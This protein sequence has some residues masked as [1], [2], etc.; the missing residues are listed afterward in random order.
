[1]AKLHEYLLSEV[2]PIGRTNALF[3]KNLGYDNTNA[4]TLERDLLNLARAGDLTDSVPSDYG[5]KYVITG[6]L[7]APN[8]ENAV[9]KT[10]WII[11]R[12]ESRPRFVTAYPA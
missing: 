7:S 4:G 1:M 5:T 9:L 12:R 11:D 3:L 6:V 8:G 2:H 10:V